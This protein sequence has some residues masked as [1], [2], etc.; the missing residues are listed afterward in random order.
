MES[1]VGQVGNAKRDGDTAAEGMIVS[2]C[3]AVTEID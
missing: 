3:A 2:E 1:L